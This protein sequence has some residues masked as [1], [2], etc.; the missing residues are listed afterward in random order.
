MEM[1]KL[2]IVAFRYVTGPTIPTRA[3][4]R[5]SATRMDEIGRLTRFLACMHVNA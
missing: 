1:A 4:L 3:R 5:H 2:P